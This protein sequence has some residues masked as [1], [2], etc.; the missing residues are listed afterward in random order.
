[1]KLHFLVICFVKGKRFWFSWIHI[2]L[3]CST[4]QIAI[5]L[6]KEKEKKTDKGW[7]DKGQKA[8]QHK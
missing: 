4:W 3:K 6:K 7:K 1:M 2:C 8:A 5:L